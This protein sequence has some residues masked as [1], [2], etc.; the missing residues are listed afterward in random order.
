M[1]VTPMEYLGAVTAFKQFADDAPPMDIAHWHR[2]INAFAVMDAK[3]RGIPFCDL[4]EADLKKIIQQVA[5]TG[6]KPC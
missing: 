6:E 1:G 5:Q 3:N 2:L 4:A